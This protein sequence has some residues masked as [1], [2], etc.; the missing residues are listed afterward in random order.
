[1]YPPCTADYIPHV[2]VTVAIIQLVKGRK[3]AQEGLSICSHVTFLR[4]RAAPRRAKLRRA[5]LS[6]RISPIT[7]ILT[8]EPVLS[9]TM[10]RNANGRPVKAYPSARKANAAGYA[11]RQARKV[12]AG[13]LS[14]VYEHQQQRMRRDKVKLD[15]DRDEEADRGFAGSDDEGFDRDALRARLIGENVD[16]EMIDSEDDEET[17]K[18][19]K[20]RARQDRDKEPSEPSNKRAKTGAGRSLLAGAG[21]GAG[22]G[23]S[24]SRA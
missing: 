2:L 15:L 22:A 5:L 4:F 21:A 24:G 3:S 16:N 9:S 8:P 13:A 18:N 12:K 17:P 14:D 19:N 23:P 10:A 20:K 7:Y 6:A 1:M 11:K